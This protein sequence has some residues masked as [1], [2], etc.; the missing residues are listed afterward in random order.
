[1]ATL[2]RTGLRVEV[3]GELDLAF[4]LVGA[5]HYPGYY[6]FNPHFL[7]PTSAFAPR[8]VQLAAKL[9]F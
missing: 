3:G 1:M 2:R 4:P 6:T 9:L 7:V 5:T 8:Q